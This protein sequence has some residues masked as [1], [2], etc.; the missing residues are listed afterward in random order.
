[1]LGQP[2]LNASVSN[3]FYQIL[4]STTSLGSQTTVTRS[5]LLLP[6]PQYSGVAQAN[7]SFGYSWYNSA[8][9]R[10]EYRM[11]H[12]LFVQAGYTISKTLEA[13]SLLNA[14]DLSLLRQKAAFDRPQRFVTSV[15]YH[16]PVGPNSHFL[17]KGIASHVV[18]GWD[19]SM[20]GVAQSGAPVA[21]SNGNYMLTG[22]PLLSSGQ[23]YTQ[24]FNTSSSLWV[25]LA[26]GS[27]RVI[28][29]MSQNLRAPT[30]P[31]FNIGLARTFVIHENHQVSFRAM[32]VN[33]TNTPLFNGPNTDPTSSLFGRITLTQINLPRQVFL[34]IRYSF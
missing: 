15:T 4:P 23:S 26:A 1:V 7:N 18:G 11:K 5:T 29:T 28:P 22:S 32:A 33:A 25:P 9:F 30:A 31:Q 14:Q 27:L 10:M 16:L 2:Y 20:T 12:G 21:F 34:N 24:W 13:M 6:Y 17:N 8:Q 19:V 3:P